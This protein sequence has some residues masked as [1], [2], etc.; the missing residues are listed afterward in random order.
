MAFNL[1]PWP[2]PFWFAHRGAGREAPENTLAAFRIGLEAGFQAF[3]CDVQLSLDGLPFLLHDAL[4]AR[5]SNGQGLACAQTWAA[6]AQLDA[7]SWHSAKHAGEP[8]ASLA[9][10]E[11]FARSWGLHINLELKPSPGQAARVGAGVAHWLAAHWRAPLPLLSSFVPEALQAA[12]QVTS[13]PVRIALLQEAWTPETPR[14]ALRLGA[15]AVVCHHASLSAESV[16]ALH[17]AGL[18]ALAYTVNEV[19]EARRLREAGV[20]GLITDCMGL[21][22]QLTVP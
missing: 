18:R 1:E 19:T 8:L 14:L 17:S 7:G 13:R 6:L 22:N 16:A 12:T 21:P 11:A 2:Y 9:A 3:E 15:A 20:D 10:L 4:L 5:T